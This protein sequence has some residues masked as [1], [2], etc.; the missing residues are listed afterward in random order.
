[1]NCETVR[2][3]VK[4]LTLLFVA[5]TLLGGSMLA[6][7]LNKQV[8]FTVSADYRLS[9]QGYVLPAGNYI[10]YQINTGNPSLFALYQGDMTS[11]PIAMVQTTRIDYH[12]RWP[13]KTKMHWQLEQAYDRSIPTITG[14]QVAG[15]DGWEIIAVV[16][17]GRGIN[18]L[19][20]AR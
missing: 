2:N 17:R 20:R 15:T 10:L 9:M 4:K 12:T 18:L 13:L 16:P 14:W 6:D 8:N 5:M 1:M 19:T 3:S 7:P 11:S